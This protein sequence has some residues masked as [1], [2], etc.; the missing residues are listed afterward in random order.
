MFNNIQLLF[1]YRTDGISGGVPLFNS[2]LIYNFSDFL[3]LM[4]FNQDF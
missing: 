1:D 3:D 4:A 2:R